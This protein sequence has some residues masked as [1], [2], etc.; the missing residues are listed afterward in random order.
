MTGASEEFQYILRDESMHLNF[1]IDLINQIKAENPDLWT[2]EFQ[3]EII[4]LIKQG[5]DLNTV[6]QKTLCLAAY[7]VIM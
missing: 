3:E 1:G 6:T 5:V 2:P 7:L 4:T